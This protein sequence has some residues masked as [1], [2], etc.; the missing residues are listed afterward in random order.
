VSPHTSHCLSKRQT[1]KPTAIALP[2]DLRSTLEAAAA[3]NTALSKQSEPPLLSLGTIVRSPGQ[4]FSYQIIGPICRLYDRSELPYPCCRLQW[5]GK[6]P[7][8]NR[9]GKQYVIDMSTRHKASYQ[10]YLLSETGLVVNEE[11]TGQPVAVVL[12]WY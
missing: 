3:T 1:S 2:A 11:L 8:C 4:S 10:A 6:E 12:T 9:V 7:S 5:K